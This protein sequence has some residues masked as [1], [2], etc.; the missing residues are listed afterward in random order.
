MEYDKWVDED[1][2]ININTSNLSEQEENAES[3]AE[4][5]SNDYPNL[6]T[7]ESTTSEQKDQ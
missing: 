1:A 2:T 7:Q 6:E 5:I 3:Q 4:C